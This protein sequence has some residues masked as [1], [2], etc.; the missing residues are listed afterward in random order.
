[1]SDTPTPAESI[2]FALV[3]AA[4][5]LT[6]KPAEGVAAMIQAATE[7][8]KAKLTEAT[9]TAG[10]DEAAVEKIITDHEKDIL[11]A[12]QADKTFAEMVKRV[13]HRSV[14]KDTPRASR[15]GDFW[16]YLLSVLNASY[17]EPFDGM[18]SFSTAA[19][20]GE[21]D[22]WGVGPLWA[23]AEAIGGL[24]TEWLDSDVASSDSSLN[25]YLL[26]GGG[27]ITQGLIFWA[28]TLE[29]IAKLADFKEITLEGKAIKLVT[30]AGKTFYV[31]LLTEKPGA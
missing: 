30:K 2:P 4:G 6:G 20:T 23:K 15:P 8:L 5:H 19:A 29:T 9:A 26:Y 11:K 16:Y 13:R 27:K 12:W 18:S 10:I 24:Y 21:L 28:A 22:D 1:M 3:D 25:S 7:D 14:W 31:Q 17:N